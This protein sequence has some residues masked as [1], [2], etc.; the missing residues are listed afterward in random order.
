MSAGD[1]SAYTD[2][3][4][5]A[6]LEDRRRPRD[7]GG[8]AR[9]SKARRA[10]SNGRKPRARSFSRSAGRAC[11]TT[12]VGEVKVPFEP[13]PGTIGIL[14]KPA[15]T[16]G[17]EEG[18]EDSMPSPMPPSASAA[19]HPLGQELR[20]KRHRRAALRRRRRRGARESA[21]RA[22]ERSVGRGRGRGGSA[23][24]GPR[25]VPHRSRHRTLRGGRR[26]QQRAAIAGRHGLTP[27][28][29][30]EALGNVHRLRF[31]GPATYAVHRAANALAQE[32]GSSTP[33]RTSPRP[34]KTTRSSPPTSFSQNSGTI[35]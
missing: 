13:L 23:L 4:G 14:A 6:R 8:G 1:A 31:A 15:N 3:K 16:Q 17:E 2:Q 22:G 5:R 35:N 10:L 27:E 28:G 30:F 34:A 32:P 25:L 20:A 21:A 29:R 19:D 12:I 26:R 7:R 18:R 9:L 11:P 33:S 24:R